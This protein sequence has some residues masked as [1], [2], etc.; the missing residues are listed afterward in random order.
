MTGTIAEEYLTRAVVFSADPTPAQERLLRSYCGAARFAH[1]WA[2]GQVKDNLTIRSD[3]RAAGLS[4][5]ALTASL[6]W[7]AFSLSKTW[8]AAKDEAAPWWKEVPKHAFQSGTT[9]A[10]AGLANFSGSRKGTRGGPRMGFPKFKSRATAKPSVTFVELNHQLSWLE[11][12]DVRAG[13]SQPNGHHIRLMLPQS[14]PDRDVRRRRANLAW[15]HT[16]QSTRRLARKLESGAASIQAVTISFVGGRWQVA[17]SVRYYVTPTSKPVTFH[18]GAIGV[19]LGLTHLA[20]LSRPVAGLTD[21]VGH[22]ANP[23]V[24]ATQLTKLARLDRKLSRCQPGSKNRTKVKGQRARLHG[25]AAKTRALAL[26][27]ITNALAGG[28]DTVAIEDLHV[29]GMATKKRHLGRS[30]ADASFGEFR[31]QLA[32][33]SPDRGTTLVVVGRFYPS[34]KTCSACLADGRSAV[35][36]KLHLWE[37]VFECST[38]GMSLDRD[39]NA[40]RT[41][42]AEGRRLLAAKLESVQPMPSPQDVAGLRPETKNADPRTEKTEVPTGTAALAVSPNGD[43][44]AEPRSSR[45]LVGATT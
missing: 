24:L 27:R 11:D 22:I 36:A 3:E 32:Y 25:T 43:E 26:H 30:L 29:K 40:A 41:I 38:C 42:E 35:K 39:V 31:R 5:D 17:L 15:I 33:K 44:K 20:T 34:S 2:L 7:S 12:A 1:N 37:R 9:A 6:S 45:P 8:N 16:T 19:D 18:G 4:E 21:E 28:F 23:R 13:R 14:T 10:G